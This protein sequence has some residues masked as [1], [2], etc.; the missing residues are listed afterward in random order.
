MTALALLVAALGAAGALAQDATK[1]ADRRADPESLFFNMSK[2]NL[3][4]ITSDEDRKRYLYSIQLEKARITRKTLRAVY[5]N[6][7][8]LYKAGDYEGS[9]ELTNKILTVDPGFEDAAILQ[10]ASIEL[11]GSRKPFVSE[12][13]LVDDRFEE[14]M[15]FYR[16]GRVVE[17]S[18]K[19]EEAVKLAPGNLKARYWL[20]K[21]RGE[22]AD[23][24]FRRGQ[25]AY[26]QHRLRE[27]LDQ[28]YAALV[29]NP[30]YPR[31]VGAISKVESE[32]REQDSNDK[33]QAAL[34]LYAQGKT[35]EA[36]KQL[37][38]VLQIEPGD[39]RA[40]KLIGEI[41]LEVANQH[42]AEGRRLYESR[43]YD[44]A[45][46]EWKKAV[47]YGYDTR[48]SDQLVARAR[49]QKRREADAKTK[50]EQDRQRR[51]EEARQREEEAARKTEE[52]ARKKTEEDKKQLEVS[53]ADTPKVNPTNMAGVPAAPSE[54]DKREAVKHWNA[55]IIF[56]QKGDYEKARDEWQICKQMDPSN[57]DCV[58]GLQRID[59]SYGSGP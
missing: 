14:G 48:S 46:G 1:P 27:A 2:I 35:D 19:W 3:G 6:A 13:K 25:K 40:T 7:Y 15:A 41:R 49:D 17:A 43:N 24:H 16:Q 9:R 52:E 30:R 5:E 10:R 22:I 21:S 32:V 4:T 53:K 57:S 39:A 42:V 31:L 18:E 33:L 55:G 12:K 28:W 44:G 23:E 36:L 47:T 26:R 34:N 51:A 29:L 59:Q 8:D 45:I 54:N 37:D 56:Y 38:G 20:K 11:N 58:T 50:A